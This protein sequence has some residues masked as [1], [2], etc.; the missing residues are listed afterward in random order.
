MNYKVIDNF[1]KEEDF[2]L[3]KSTMLGGEF[4]W[5]YQDSKVPTDPGPYDFQFTHIFY[6]NFNFTSDY[7]HILN[8]IFQIIKPASILRVKANLTPKTPEIITYGY[9]TDFGSAEKIKTAVYYVNTNNGVT[10]FENGPKIES[11]ENRFLVFDNNIPHAGTSC[12]DEKVRCVI[13]INYYEFM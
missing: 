4:A 7:A 1:L 9:H 13:N 10:D 5:F 12:T 11:I 3:I 8:P 2:Q 6:Q